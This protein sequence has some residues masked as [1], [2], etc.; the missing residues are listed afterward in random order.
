MIKINVRKDVIE[1]YRYYYSK[2]QFIRSSCDVNKVFIN[3]EWKRYTEMISDDNEVPSFNDSVLVAESDTELNIKLSNR[4]VNAEDINQSSDCNAF[5]KTFV[6]PSF[7][8]WL[9]TGMFSMNIGEYK[10]TIMKFFSSNC[11]IHETEYHAYI[12]SST[13]SLFKKILNESIIID[14]GDTKSLKEWYYY[15]TR[16]INEVW[17]EY[18]LKTYFDYICL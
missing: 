13:S 12:D 11:S 4:I 3:N 14:T 6:F 16:K 5:V 1:L 18:F 17:V 10:C 7:D 2:T 9:I 8:Q 15:I